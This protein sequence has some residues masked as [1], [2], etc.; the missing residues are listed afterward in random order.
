MEGGNKKNF[1]IVKIDKGIFSKKDETSLMNKTFSNKDSYSA[2]KKAANAILKKTTQ[3]KKTIKFI[4]ENQKP[5]KNGVK[6]Q[7]AYTGSRNDNEKI[8]KINGKELKF[9][10]SSNVKS[11]LKTDI[12]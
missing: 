6:K 11:C 2:A 10:E 12:K 9:S 7:L 8:V 1:K 4:L 3:K 5:N